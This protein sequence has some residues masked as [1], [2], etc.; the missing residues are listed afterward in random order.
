[1]S[2]IIIPVGI[3]GF[4]QLRTTGCYYVDKTALVEELVGAQGNQVTLIT[5]PRRFGKTLA[6]NMLSEFFDIR[7]DSRKLFE[8]LT[9]SR[10]H[11]VCDAWMNQYP[12]L[13]L[14]FKDVG[15]NS[16]ENAFGLLRAAIGDV[17]REHS[18]LLTSDQTVENDRRDFAELSAGTAGRKT[19]Q[20]SIALLTRML[21]AHY[22]KPVVLLLD[23]YD[24]PIS[25]AS[26]SYKG[27]ADYYSE[28]MEIMRPMIS[29]A[30]KDNPALKL[31]VI[32][33]CLRIGKESIFTG[34]NNMV[35]NTISDTRLN[36][37]FG[38]TQP[39]IDRLLEDTNLTDHRRE[40]QEWY[41]G[42]CFGNTRIYCPW[43]VM[44]HVSRL[45]YEP[46]A[47]PI[48]YW[49]NS[50][51]NAII[52]SFL[53]YSGDAISKKFEILMSGG[54]IAEKIEENLTYDYLHSS[55]E[56][57]WSIL[58]LTGYLTRNPSYEM[59]PDMDNAGKTALIIPNREVRDIFES[60]IQVWFADYARQWNR[61]ALFAAVWSGDADTLTRELTK[62]LRKTISYHDYR[63]D[64]Y[65]AFFAGVFAGAGYSVESNRE[66]GEGRSDI[67]VMDYPGDRAAVFEV[68]Y[69][70][71]QQE[72]ERDCDIARDQIDTRKYAADLED[73]YAQIRC[74]GIAFYKKRCLVKEK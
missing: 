1:M 32:T 16:F 46:T 22:G 54:T 63:E 53:D 62:L 43:D 66:H 67:L 6:M 27:K 20:T 24:V 40:M 74:Y 59:N 73:D 37:F 3:S 65:H 8:G 29:T 11:T 51:D 14:T 18:Y 17:C 44:N 35:S 25:K 9:V 34:A 48:G 38:F 50:S 70:K 10:N 72:M 52:R 7:K 41:D 47:R 28:M 64:F 71:A 36:E 68:K 39:E 45:M 12:T 58:Y 5:R 49:K 23:E 55:E 61:E 2:D 19:V 21:Q 4:A 42:Y 13:F 30:I 26:G 56:N 60:T 57:L 69:S 31:A 15:G 33:G